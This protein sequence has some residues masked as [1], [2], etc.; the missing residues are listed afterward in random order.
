MTQTQQMALLFLS[1]SLLAL[2]CFSLL[3][4]VSWLDSLLVIVIDDESVM[5]ASIFFVSS[6]SLL[7]AFLI[8]GLCPF[9]LLCSSRFGCWT[10]CHRSFTPLHHRL[11][12]LKAFNLVR[13]FGLYT[14]AFLLLRSFDLCKLILIK[15]RCSLLLFLII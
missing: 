6:A 11:N 7:L 1:C 5:R 13:I 8:L 14:L 9:L 3:S 4:V 2:G 12:H 15:H 10:L